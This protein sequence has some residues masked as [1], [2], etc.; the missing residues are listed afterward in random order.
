MGEILKQ[1]GRLYENEYITDENDNYRLIMQND[2]NLVV[3][4]YYD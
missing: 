2:G 3:Y 1:D 4:N